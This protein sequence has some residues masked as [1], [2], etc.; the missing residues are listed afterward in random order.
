[1]LDITI[2]NGLWLNNGDFVMVYK[3]YYCCEGCHV[4]PIKA[5]T[6]SGKTLAYLYPVPWIP[7]RCGLLGLLGES[8]RINM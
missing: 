1:M 5:R 7:W 4:L 6:G 8:P 2:V 3:P